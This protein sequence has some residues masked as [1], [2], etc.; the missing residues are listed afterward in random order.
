M[1]VHDNLMQEVI[2]ELSISDEDNE[3]HEIEIINKTSKNIIIGRPPNGKIKPFKT[4]L[5]HSFENN[6]SK[7]QKHRSW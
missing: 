5:R 2:I 6:T 4:H 3:T 1:F 7:K